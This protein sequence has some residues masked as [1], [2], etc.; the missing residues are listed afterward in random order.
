MTENEQLNVFATVAGKYSDGLSLIFDGEE[1]AT[2]KHYK[3][4]PRFP[5]AVGERVKL[6]KDSGTY[7][8]DF[9]VG[10]PASKYIIADLPANPTTSDLG[11]AVYQILYVL[12][13]LGILAPP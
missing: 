4:N 8:V 3:C 13:K 7:V 12:R 1:K 6:T 2:A 9:P 11:T 5:F 10:L